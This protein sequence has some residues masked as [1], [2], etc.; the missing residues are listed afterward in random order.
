MSFN[1]Q[2]EEI[3]AKDNRGIDILPKLQSVLPRKALL[4]ICKSFIRPHFDYGGLIYDQLYNYLFHAKL[5]SYQFKVVL[6]MTVAIKESPPENLY[7]ELGIEHLSSRPW[8]K[9][10]FLRNI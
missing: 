2:L 10:F 7:H 5:E 8:L 9:V 4:T 3:I 6:V 1:E